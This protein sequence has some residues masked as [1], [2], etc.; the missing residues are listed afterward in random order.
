M[1]YRHSARL[2]DLKLTEPNPAEMEGHEYGYTIFEP[3][4]DIDASSTKS[5][6][7]S[8]M[9][10]TNKETNNHNDDVEIHFPLCSEKLMN[11]QNRDNFYKAILKL[12]DE[13][14]LSPSEKYFVN[15]K[16]LLHICQWQKALALSCEWVI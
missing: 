11:M 8:S 15:N 13:K 6:P 2:V 10:V 14:K 5:T 9:T 3:L 7:V 1:V 12:I 4:P 16:K